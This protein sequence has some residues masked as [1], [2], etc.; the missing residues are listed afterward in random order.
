M[1]FVVDSSSNLLYI[2]FNKLYLLYNRGEMKMEMYKMAY[3]CYTAT[4]ESYG[5]ES[6]NFHYFIKYLTEEQLVAYSMK[7]K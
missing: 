4:C 6:V 5:M 1:Y 7:I 2:I 3:E